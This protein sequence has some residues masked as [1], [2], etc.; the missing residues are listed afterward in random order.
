MGGSMAAKSQSSLVITVI[1]GLLALG[2]GLVI[3]YLLRPFKDSSRPPGAGGAFWGRESSD[4][5][6]LAAFELLKDCS[7]MAREDDVISKHL[8]E[9]DVEA[10]RAVTCDIP[11]PRT[12][13][14]YKLRGNDVIDLDGRLDDDAWND[15]AWTDSFVDIQGRNFPEPRLNTKVKMRYDDRFLY[16]AAFLQEP[17]VWANVTLHDG[18]VYQ[19]NSFQARYK[20]ITINARGTVADLMMTKSYVDSGEPLTFWES[21]LVS[22]VFIQGSLNNP[23]VEGSPAK[24]D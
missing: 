5:N 18:T 11:Y 8:L 24:E 12:Y 13:V 21:D 4:E 2:V 16:I 23:K 6:K 3:G 10:C 1:V 22:E 20:E 15:V 9:N 17:D 19:D 14:I 7:H